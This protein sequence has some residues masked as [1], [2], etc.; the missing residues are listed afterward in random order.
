[1]ENLI[2]GATGG[3]LQNRPMICGGTDIYGNISRMCYEIIPEGMLLRSEYLECCYI[4]LTR[5]DTKVGYRGR[6]P[7][8][9]FGH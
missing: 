6:V 5:W 2:I 4:G 1:M 3:L 9:E 7:S 8:L